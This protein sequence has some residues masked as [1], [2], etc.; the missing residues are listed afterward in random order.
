MNRHI[1]T[2]ASACT[3]TNTEAHLLPQASLLPRLQDFLVDSLFM[4]FCVSPAAYPGRLD[5]DEWAIFTFSTL[6]AQLHCNP[7]ARVRA[8]QIQSC[9]HQHRTGLVNLSLRWL[10]GEAGFVWVPVTLVRR[11]AIW[12][13][14]N[15]FRPSLP[16][17]LIASR[18]ALAGV[19]Q[20]GTLSARHRQSTTHPLFVAVGSINRPD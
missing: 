20:C 6:P 17:S 9:I 11:H 16:A 15:D 12:C 1:H 3:F 8:V 13:Q 4:G 10:N 14:V 19:I 2:C 7:R 18:V 5:V